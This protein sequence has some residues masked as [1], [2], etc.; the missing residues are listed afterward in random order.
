MIISARFFILS[1]FCF[2]D[3]SL[4]H[5]PVVVII[6][7]AA[8]ILLDSAVPFKGKDFICQPVKKIPIVRNSYN[9]T[10]EIIE[11]VLENGKCLHIKIISRLIQHQHVRGPHQHPQ[12][13]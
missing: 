5:W 9:C 1:L 2:G 4:N 7:I 13:I 3:T 12:K 6:S 10:R 8:I 11:V